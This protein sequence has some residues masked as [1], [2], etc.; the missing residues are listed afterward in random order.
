MQ[1]AYISGKALACV[2]T[3]NIPILKLFDA[4]VALHIACLN[5][6]LIMGFNSISLF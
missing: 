4:K 6:V 2:I 5:S 1:R 3:Y